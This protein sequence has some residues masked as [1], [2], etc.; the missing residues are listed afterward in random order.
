MGFIFAGVLV[1]AFIFTFLCVP[2]CKGKSLEQIDRLF[3]EGVPLR[4][5]GAVSAQEDLEGPDDTQEEQ[6]PKGMEKGVLTKHEE[7]ATV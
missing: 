5:F 2:E 3:H 7:R 4:K 1:L 6:Q